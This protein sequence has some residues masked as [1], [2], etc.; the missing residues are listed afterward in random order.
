MNRRKH[1]TYDVEKDIKLAI[2]Y[3]FDKTLTPDDMQAQGFIQSLDYKVEDFW[4][5]SNNLAAQNEMDQNLSYMYMMTKE[6]R[7]K[8]LFTRDTLRKAGSAIRFF[9]GVSTW[10]DRIN[11]YGK[12]RGVVVEHFII[13]SG[14][15]EMIEG[16]EIAEKFKRIYASSFTYDEQNV[17]VWPA[18]AVNY[19]NKT[20]FLFRIEKGIL[21]VNDQN[22]NTYYEPHE[23]DVPF[24][25]MVYIGDSD[26]DIPCMKLVNANGGH[27]IGVYN[28]E[29]RDKSK[30]FRM[31]DE[32]RIK[33]FAPADYSEGSPMDVLVKQIIDRTYANEVLEKMHYHCKAEK[34]TETKNQSREEV[35]KDSLI[36]ALEDSINFRSTHE[37]IRE[38]RTI[39]NWS[40]HQKR[41]LCSIAL[42]NSQVRSIL[43]DEDLKGFYTTLCEGLDDASA[44]AVLALIEE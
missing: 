23:Y 34:Y 17:P 20:Q 11:E 32:G 26:T 10:F 27:S 41:K 38:L 5:A 22:V 18:Q 16:T 13:S 19:T 3:D 8:V 12:Q 24:R 42:E 29:T 25:N 7:G 30:V 35:Y 37:A 4:A 9:D 14:L 44:K 1:E 31:L 36:D 28:P 40:R 33:F 21:D 39:P 43:K 15:K 6:S 2:C